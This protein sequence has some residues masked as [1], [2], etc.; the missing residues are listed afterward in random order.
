MATRGAAG[1]TPDGGRAY[2]G[3]RDVLGPNLTVLFVGFNPGHR[4]GLTGR[5][6]AG[7]KPVLALLHESGLTHQL[8]H[9]DED[10]LVLA[11][12]YGITNIVTRTTPQASELRAHEYREGA[13]ELKRKVEVCGPR[14]I[15]CLG[16]GS[17][18]R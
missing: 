7:R 2:T 18:L 1:G 11:G 5:H 8:L 12:G 16:K 14:I 6:F 17:T 10:R 3:T 9:P 13:T 15:C 4:S